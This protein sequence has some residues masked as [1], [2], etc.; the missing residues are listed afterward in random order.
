MKKLFILVVLFI[1]CNQFVNA[2]NCNQFVGTVNGKKLIYLNQDAKGN[3]QGKLIYTAT[4]KDASTVSVHSEVFDKNG[5]SVGGGDSEMICSGDAIK[6]DM[7]AF[8]PAS[9][10]KQ[11]SN[12]QMTGE[13]KYL[14][15]PLNLSAGQKLD[16]GAVTIDM[17]NNGQPMSQI[18]M[19]ITN[20][21]VDKAETVNTNAGSFD[22][23]RITYDATMKIKMM[24]IGIPVHI[25]AAEWFAPKLGRFVK[26]ETYDKKSK[27]MGTMILDAIN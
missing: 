22:C 2:Q 13:A 11:F 3:A 5:K 26:S 27:L 19:D 8:V 14:A 12:M 20:R 6:I 9:S 23:Y 4:K 1:F 21:M 10:M 25:K 24:G 16:D 18:Q 7:K 17:S 15:Y